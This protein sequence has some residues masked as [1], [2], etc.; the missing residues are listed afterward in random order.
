MN[1]RS[2]PI[3]KTAS[4]LIQTAPAKGNVITTLASAILSNYGKIVLLLGA[5]CLIRYVVTHLKGPA[6][7]DIEPSS[8]LPE[9]ERLQAREIIREVARHKDVLALL[10]QQIP[11]LSDEIHKNLKSSTM[12]DVRGCLALLEGPNDLN[13][14]AAIKLGTNDWILPKGN[15]Q[16]NCITLIMDGSETLYYMSVNNQITRTLLT[17]AGVTEAELE[18]YTDNDWL[19]LSINNHQLTEVKGYESKTLPLSIEFIPAPKMLPV[20]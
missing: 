9:N 3:G 15:K 2:N 7:Q 4:A 10:E 17:Q 14:I 20:I 1:N 13:F 16:D 11:G 8:E 18:Q 6:Q 19:T 5:A 12:D